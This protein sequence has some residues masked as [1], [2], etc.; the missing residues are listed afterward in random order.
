MTHE[1]IATKY[2]G[3]IL[4]VFTYVK[5]GQHGCFSVNKSYFVGATKL[6]EYVDGQSAVN[7]EAF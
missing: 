2:Y 5:D 1:A 7:K 4:I 6:I 3:E